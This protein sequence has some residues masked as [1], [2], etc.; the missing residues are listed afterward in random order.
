MSEKYSQKENKNP[1]NGQAAVNRSVLVKSLEKN[2]LKSSK[3]EIFGY[4]M[5][6]TGYIFMVTLLRILFER[7]LEEY[8]GCFVNFG[9]F[10]TSVEGESMIKGEFHYSFMFKIIKVLFR[11]DNNRREMLCGSRFQKT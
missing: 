10:R 8:T 2:K 5:I 7:L 6:P 3:N 4:Y 1:L 11:F 9:S